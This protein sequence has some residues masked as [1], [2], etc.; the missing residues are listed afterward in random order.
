MSCQSFLN[1]F[2][3]FRDPRNQIIKVPPEILGG[4][5]AGSK[6]ALGPTVTKK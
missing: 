2:G 1:S 3:D 6:G 4:F 5:R